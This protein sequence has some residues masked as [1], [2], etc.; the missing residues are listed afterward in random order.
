[1]KVQLREFTLENFNSIRVFADE[2]NEPWFVAKDIC[3]AL[4]IKNSRDALRKSLDDD[5]RGT[6]KVYTPGG[7]QEMATVSE[8]GFYSIVFASRKDEAKKFR[9]WVTSEVLPQI[10]KTGKY[11]PKSAPKAKPR[12][13]HDEIAHIITTVAH[14]ARFTYI[15]NAL[16]LELTAEALKRNGFPCHSLR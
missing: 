7:P 2:N 5:E 3:D 13:V 11:A 9:K 4:E 10:R 15:P 8:S 12:P 14:A 6:A 16:A 1:M